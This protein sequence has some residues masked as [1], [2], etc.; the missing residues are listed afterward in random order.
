MDEDA[1]KLIERARELHRDERYEEAESILR[2]GLEGYPD[3][4][5][6]KVEL[7]ITLASMARDERAERVL[8]SV[9][10][11]NPTHERA[12][13][14]LGRLLDSCL[15][16]DEAEAIYRD[17]IE[18][19]PRSHH[20][21]EDL[22]RLLVSEG[23]TPEALSLAREHAEAY[24]RDYEAYDA[25]RVVLLKIED[26]MD[27]FLDRDLGKPENLLRVLSN[28]L[29]QYSVYRQMLEQVEQQT[30]ETENRR[31]ILEDEIDRVL[32]E[33]CALR[34]HIESNRDV[35]SP[36]VLAAADE[37]TSQRSASE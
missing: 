27:S 23:R 2:N 19:E 22:V 24:P 20:V 21:F 15:R 28:L 25:L 33:I 7:G 8:R 11:T 34:D 1:E 35:L 6:L 29:E 9:L 13:G 14:A 12:A 5:E 32:A 17:I 31:E 18:L 26:D 10:D 3:N 30:L 4:E 16:S 36:G 37:L